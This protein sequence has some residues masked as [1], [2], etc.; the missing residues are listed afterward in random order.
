MTVMS[1]IE[2]RTVIN[3]EHVCVEGACAELAWR[4]K[5]QLD[6]PKYA[7]GVSLMPMPASVY[8]WRAG[9]RTARKRADRCER[10]GYR[11]AVIDRSRFNDDI[12]AINT[13]LAERQ[14]RPMTDGYT[15]RHNH[16]ALPEYRCERHRVHTYGILHAD[17]LVAYLT[18]YRVGQLALV[19]MILGH[20]AHLKNDIM[21]LLAAGTIDDQAD[22][23]GVLY[24]NRWDSGTDGLR[25]YKERVGFAAGDV[26]WLL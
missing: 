17:T 3:L 20:G 19:S 12:H 22:K 7:T 4:F 23:G 15:R 6:T 21:Y 8:E 14:G 16:G 25:Y 9:H 13:S 1:D 26:D 10:L 11:F 5:R 18:L 24:Y 2:V